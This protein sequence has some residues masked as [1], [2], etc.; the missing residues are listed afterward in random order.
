MA[1]AWSNFFGFLIQLILA[2]LMLVRKS[3]Q[4][5]YNSWSNMIVLNLWSE[6]SSLSGSIELMKIFMVSI[7]GR[8]VFTLFPHARR[9]RAS[10]FFSCSR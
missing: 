4:L 10:S 2:F 6:N 9:V 5:V 1:V 3:L 8:N 7:V